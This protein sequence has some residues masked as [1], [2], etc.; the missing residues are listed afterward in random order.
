MPIASGH[1]ISLEANETPE[2]TAGH[3]EKIMTLG[4]HRFESRHRRK[5][6]SIFDIEVNGEFV[7]DAEGNPANVIFVIRDITER[8]S[9]EKTLKKSQML[10]KSS[11]ESQKDTFFFS[12]DRNYQYLLFNKAHAESG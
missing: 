4:E 2:V 3:I 7:R 6:G 11:I 8:K 1:P 5:D 10:L 12:I 9:A